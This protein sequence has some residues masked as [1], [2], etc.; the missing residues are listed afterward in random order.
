MNFVD[1]VINY[2]KAGDGGCGKVAFRREKYVPYGGPSGGNGG[3]GGSVIFIG[4]LGENN[5]FKLQYRKKIKALNGYN[6][7]NKNKN[8]ANAPDLF[9]EVPLGCLIYNHENNQLIGEILKAGERLVIARGG[10]GGKGN[11]ALAS[12]ANPAPS[13]AEK[14]DLGENIIV[15][16]ELK[17]LADVGLLGFPN[18]GK[19]SLLAALSNAKPKIAP[20]PFTTLTPYLGMVFDKKLNFV[21]ADIP[22]LIENASLGRGQ[23]IHFLKHIERCK[24][25]LHICDASSNDI[26]SEYLLLNKELKNYHINM[27]KKP[28]IIVINKS[29]LPGF[30]KNFIFLSEKL[31]DKMII[32]ISAINYS[33]LQELKKT[34]IEHLQKNDLYNHEI[35]NDDIQEKRIFTLNEPAKFIISQENN[36]CF[37]VTGNYI[38]KLFH[39]TDF[40]NHESIS[41]FS[42]ILKKIGVEEELK[43]RGMKPCDQVK[44]GNYIFEF[45][46]E[47]NF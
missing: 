7:E 12:H 10:K 9:V 22:G 31:K 1:E 41:R 25:L 11:F 40:N 23:G 32:P 36:G 27:L 13:Y 47:K 24:L 39:R 3:H 37:I 29:D 8:G 30:H 43:K 19:S 15:R 28:Q 14:G 26:Y 34:I 2:V 44:I 5:L 45:V 42:Y 35:I 46:N 17:M 16:T 18:V 4:V 33:G 38:E 6:G 20:Y 21:I